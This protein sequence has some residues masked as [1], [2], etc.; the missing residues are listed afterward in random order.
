MGLPFP[1]GTP[2]WTDSKGTSTQ[3]RSSLDN[4]IYELI[5][6]AILIFHKYQAPDWNC[7]PGDAM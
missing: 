6:F 7:R 3:A 2:Y 1:S 5:S 4:E